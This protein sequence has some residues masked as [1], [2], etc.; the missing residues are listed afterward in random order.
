MAKNSVTSRVRV[1]KTGKIMRRAMALGH[2]R[3]NKTPLQ[4]MRKK[5]SRGLSGMHM[6]KIQKYN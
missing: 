3:S 1:T 2:S 5:R 6:Y 4:M